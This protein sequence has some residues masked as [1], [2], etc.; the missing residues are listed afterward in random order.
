MSF[1]KIL[2]RI[3]HYSQ[4]SSNLSEIKKKPFLPF[5]VVIV[6]IALLVII[7]IGHGEEHE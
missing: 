4:Q 3:L 5:Q 6:W 1:I 7:E 2:S